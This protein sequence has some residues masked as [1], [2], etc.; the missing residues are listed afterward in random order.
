MTER[1]YENG[2]YRAPG[3]R[4]SDLAAEKRLPIGNDNFRALM[5]ESVFVDKSLLVADVLGRGTAVSLYCRPRRFGKSLNLS[6]L[7]AFLEIENPSDPAW[8]NPEPLFRGLGIWEVDGVRIWQPTPWCAYPST[9]PRTSPGP[10]SCRRCA[11]PWPPNTP[12]TAISRRVPPFRQTRG[13][14]SGV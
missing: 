4:L 14:D 2:I 9:T 6:M 1:I 10:W 3:A 5:H 12:G 11:R 13:R 7:Q 8:E